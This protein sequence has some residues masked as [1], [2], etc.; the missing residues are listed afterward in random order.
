M[1]VRGTSLV[2]T[3]GGAGGFIPPT[4]PRPDEETVDG[5]LLRLFCPGKGISMMNLR[6]CMV[7]H[8]KYVETTQP[9]GPGLGGGGLAP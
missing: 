9:R 5:S 7:N 3:D 1:H 2:T 4:L 8:R 6:I